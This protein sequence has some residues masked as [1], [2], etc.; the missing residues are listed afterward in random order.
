MENSINITTRQEN[1]KNQEK[2]NLR[3]FIFQNPNAQGF[4]TLSSDTYKKA[5]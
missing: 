3:A 2:L 5:K 1:E 4:L